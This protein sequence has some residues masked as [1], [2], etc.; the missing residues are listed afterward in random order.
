MGCCA[1]K[2]APR[3]PPLDRAV[4]A[5]VV[6]LTAGP[7]HGEAIHWTAAAMAKAVGISVS[8]V[9][10]IWRAHGLKPH[11]V[12]QFKLSNDPAFAAKLKDIVGLYVDPPDHSAAWHATG[13]RSRGLLRQAHTAEPQA[14][15]IQIGRR[16]A[17]RHHPY[18]DEANHAPK[19]FVWTAKPRK[20]LA[21]VKRGREV[22]DSIH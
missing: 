15:G 1:T 11:Q 17:S 16:A 10:R 9:Q 5:R 12:R 6:D 20:I 13:I 3:K 8:S 7:P 21:A 19:P 14:W 2:H 22:L 4:I 18:I